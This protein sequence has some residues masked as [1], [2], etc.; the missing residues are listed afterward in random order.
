MIFLEYIFNNAHLD[1]VGYSTAA[2]SLFDSPDFHHAPNHL[3]V[4]CQEWLTLCYYC[5]LFTWRCVRVVEFRED[6]LRHVQQPFIGTKG[7]LFPQN[8][9]E[10]KLAAPLE[11]NCER[12][13]HRKSVYSCLATNQSRVKSAL[14]LLIPWRNWQMRLKMRST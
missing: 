11:L 2:C 6:T 10:F 12:T 13:L 5:T 9:L 14:L 7:I 3:A 8:T 4:R 1:A